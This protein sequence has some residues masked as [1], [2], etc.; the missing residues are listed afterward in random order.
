MASMLSSASPL[1]S[2]S[3]IAVASAQ[4]CPEAEVIFARGQDEPAGMGMIGDAFVSVLRD[5]TGKQIGSYAVNYP[6]KN[7]DISPGVADMS[8]HIQSMVASC[9]NTRLI[10]GGYSLG[11]G[12]T[13]EVLA[14][15]LPPGADQHIAAVVTFGNASR[16]VGAPLAPGPQYDG[17]TYDICN[18]G[19]PI[20]SG[21]DALLSHFQ[22]AYISAGSPAVDFAASRL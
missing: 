16:L 3:T 9:P 20:C 4:P 11:G 10:V 19:D 6:A 5:R 13:N 12:V 1:W 2:S 21:G 8:G 22:L 7:G 15:R 18:P 17:K 14:N